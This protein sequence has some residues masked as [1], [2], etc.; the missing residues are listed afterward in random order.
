MW[1]EPACPLSKVFM[2]D[3][4]SIKTTAPKAS[5]IDVPWLIVHGTADDVVPIEDS[6]RIYA[7]ANEPK[8]LVEIP[9]ANH[10]FSDDGLE[11]MSEAVISWIGEVL[12]S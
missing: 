6:K 10:V 7:K 2:E 5:D 3:L 12:Q 4:K 9:N 11:S 1:E 8:K